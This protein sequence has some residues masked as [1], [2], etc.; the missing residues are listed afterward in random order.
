MA[1]TYRLTFGRRL[2]NALLKGLLRLGVKLGPV[3][4]LSVMGRKSGKLHTTPVSLVEQDGQRWL[5]WPYGEMNWVRNA[6]ASRSVLLTRGRRAEAVRIVEVEPEER[7][8]ILKQY[9]AYN[10][11]T[12]PYF[13]AAPEAPLEAFQAEAARHPVFRIAGPA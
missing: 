9:I 3:Y 10:R 4:L 6:R 2:A 8:P 5:V 13:D 11:S 7:A 12:R 1:K